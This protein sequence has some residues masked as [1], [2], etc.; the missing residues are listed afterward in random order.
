MKRLIAVLIIIFNIFILSSCI[1]S[2]PESIILPK[3]D[4]IKEV[5][6]VEL[7]YYKND[8]PK[9][10]AMHDGDILRYDFNKAQVIEVLN[11]DKIQDIIE[12][13]CSIRYWEND[14][15]INE[16]I[17]W[18]VKLNLKDDGFYLFFAKIVNDTFFP[19]KVLQYNKSG[20]LVK[21]HGSFYSCETYEEIA[22]R[23]FEKYGSMLNG[24]A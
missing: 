18:C 3:E 11:D 1:V 8:N 15:I 9:E 22:K 20:E 12:D 19:A 17:G 10:I 6:S 7:V 4:M 23:Y 24:V 21:Y 2:D 14:K 13:F 5:K 16:P